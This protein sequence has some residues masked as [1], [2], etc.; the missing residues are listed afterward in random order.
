MGAER[1]KP[2][3]EEH[4]LYNSVYVKTKTGQLLYCRV[5]KTVISSGGVVSDNEE[6]KGEDR[7][8][9]DQGAGL[10]STFTL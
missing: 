2:G 8:F 10:V 3:T 9:L 5:V 4:I 6:M 1:K 7:V